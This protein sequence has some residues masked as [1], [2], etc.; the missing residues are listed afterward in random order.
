VKVMNRIK[1][2]TVLK[3]RMKNMSKDELTNISE[4]LIE[5]KEKELQLL[6]KKK[7]MYTKEIEKQ[8]EIL[9]RNKE[10]LEKL[11]YEN[12][13]L[14]D[15]YNSLKRV[16]KERG[17]VIDIINDNYA[18]REW[19]NLSLNKEGDCFIVYSK[20]GE[21]IKELDRDTTG[22]FEEIIKEQGRY[23]LVAIRVDIKHIKALLRLN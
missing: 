22:I 18:V 19:D 16:I 13:L 5:K 3:E 1:L 7:G 10:N 6:E 12:M 20:R 17:V 23:S 2:T 4:R 15:R 8:E 9:K 11:E 14:K 21:R